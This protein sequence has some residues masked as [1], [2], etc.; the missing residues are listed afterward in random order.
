V[1]V[2]GGNIDVSLLAKII[3][4]GLAKDGRR[5]RFR[6]HLT[7]RPG[8]LHLLTRILEDH[9]ANIVEIL[10]N[11]SNYGVSLG[12]TAIDITLETRGPAH[13]LAISHALDEANYL[14]ERI[15]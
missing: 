11:R 13:V 9:Q 5:V 6:V 15:E 10:H 8:A 1:L 4:R 3:E 12:D 14:H 2:C 7:D